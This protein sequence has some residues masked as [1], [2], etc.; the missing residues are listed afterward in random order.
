M[1]QQISRLKPFSEREAWFLFRLAAFGEALGW[2]LL[3][4]G[5][6]CERYLPNHS[7]IPVLLAGR[8]HG[9]LFLLYALAAIGLAPSL[10]WRPLRAL[11]AAIASVPPYGSL[12]FERWEAHTR[13]IHAKSGQTIYVRVQVDKKVLGVQPHRGVE[14]HLPST[15]IQRGETAQQAAHRLIIESLGIP[16][17]AGMVRL[18]DR[19]PRTFRATIPHAPSALDLTPYIRATPDIEDARFIQP[20]RVVNNK[21]A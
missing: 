3:I 20:H 12:A 7:H 15:T 18:D 6:G 8:I 21:F 13:S 9:T 1:W 2:T 4:I 17:R 10:G 16:L 14:W 19:H 11:C 5:I